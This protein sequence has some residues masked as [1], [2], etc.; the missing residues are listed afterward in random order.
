MTTAALPSPDQI[1][2]DLLTTVQ[3]AVAEY[4]TLDTELVRQRPSPDRWTIQEVVGHLIDSAA[5]NHQ[6]FVRA[7]FTTVLVFPKYEQNEWVAGQAYNDAD[8]LELL[9]LWLAYNRH[10][11]HVLRRVPDGALGVRCTIGNYAPATLHFLMADYVVHLRHH[12][13][14]IAERLPP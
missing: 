6:R 1:A 13:Q 2:D 14:K 10:L 4:R 3:Q 11:A 9:D 12:L 8:W 7:Q 5:N